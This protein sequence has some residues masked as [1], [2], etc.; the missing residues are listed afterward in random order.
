MS[1]TAIDGYAVVCDLL[2]GSD[3]SPQG[4]PELSVGSSADNE[5]TGR[6]VWDQNLSDGF[7]SGWVHME[8]DVNADGGP[9]GVLF[10]V[11]GVRLSYATPSFDD[12]LGFILRAGVDTSAG[13][14]TFRNIIG[15]FFRAGSTEADQVITTD[16]DSAST[17]GGK[18]TEAEG[19]A[20][21]APDGG[22]FRQAKVFADVRLQA[23]HFVSPT[24]LF[25]Q[26]FVYTT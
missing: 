14:V 24:D 20:V 16:D 22:G 26:V 18:T 6:L 10:I 19:L 9:Q 25:G 5:K 3:G 4:V 2:V 21:V 15:E 17:V 7:D 1:F 8:V 12:I 13:S 23:N 11:G